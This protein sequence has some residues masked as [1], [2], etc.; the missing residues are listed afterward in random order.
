MPIYTFICVLC[1]NEKEVLQNMDAPPPMC[2]DCHKVEMTKIYKNVGR[3][4]FK[5]SG[6]YETDYK[7][8][9]D[10]KKLLNHKKKEYSKTAEAAAEA[11]KPKCTQ[12]DIVRMSGGQEGY[13]KELR[14]INKRNKNKYGSKSNS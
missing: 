12:N 3:P 13:N 1:D 2:D 5:G 6:F 14:K 10:P 9:E 7:Y 8:H 4:Q 11:R